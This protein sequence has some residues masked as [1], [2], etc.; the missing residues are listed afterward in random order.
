MDNPGRD[1]P[2]MFARSVPDLEPDT[3]YAARFVWSDPDGIQE[4]AGKTLTKVG[5]VRTRPESMTSA[6]GKACPV[7][8]TDYKGTSV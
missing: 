6:E 5:Q 7:Y 1:A 3:A 8:P 4:Q 2:N